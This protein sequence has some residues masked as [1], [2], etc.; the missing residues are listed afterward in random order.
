MIAQSEPSGKTTGELEKEL[1]LHRDR[2]HTICKEYINKDLIYK[3][4]KRGKYH[5][6]PKSLNE[7]RIGGFLFHCNAMKEFFRFDHLPTEDHLF[8]REYVKNIIL[9]RKDRCNL[10]DSTLDKLGIFEYVMR[11]G[12]MITYTMI[13]AFES[14]SASRH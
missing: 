9:N 11:V 2:V 8:N 7:P 3:T 12:V 1:H 4:G 14:R 5:L 6:G 13:K 10:H